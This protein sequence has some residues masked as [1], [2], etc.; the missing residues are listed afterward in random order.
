MIAKMKS[1]LS[2]KGTL[3]YNEREKSEVIFVNNLTGETAAETEKQMVFRQ[4]LFIGRAKKPNGTH[5][6]L[7]RP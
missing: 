2:A 7:A 3:L 1:N 5:Y 4:N 6:Y